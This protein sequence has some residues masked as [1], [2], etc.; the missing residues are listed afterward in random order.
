MGSND[1]QGI[2]LPMRCMQVPWRCAIRTENS[3]ACD[4]VRA[5][6]VS[7]MSIM[8]AGI[9]VVHALSLSMRGCVFLLA[10]SS[11]IAR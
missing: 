8:M 2:D 7:S 4:H 9:G 10:T 6:N 11:A 3:L 1:M 5:G